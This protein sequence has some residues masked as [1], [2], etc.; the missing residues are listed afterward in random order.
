MDCERLRRDMSS[1]CYRSVP[2]TQALLE[3]FF[4]RIDT[5]LADAIK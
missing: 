1:F 2:V 3:G 4:K 5:S